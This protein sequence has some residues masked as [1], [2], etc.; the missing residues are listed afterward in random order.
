MKR[1]IGTICVIAILLVIAFYN[2]ITRFQA[3]HKPEIPESKKHYII[4][5]TDEIYVAKGIKKAIYA[6]EGDNVREVTNKGN[7]YLYKKGKHYYLVKGKNWKKVSN[8]D[9]WEEVY[10]YA[11]KH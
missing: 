7:S 5:T 9:N 8:P 3:M 1:A 4:M 11:Y 10:N 6:P 2:E